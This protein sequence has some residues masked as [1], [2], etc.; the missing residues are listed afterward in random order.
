MSSTWASRN[1]SISGRALPADHDVLVVLEPR[2][3]D[4]GVLDQVD[5]QHHVHR[6]LQPGAVDLALA[7]AGVTVAEVEVRAFVEHR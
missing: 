2:P 1:A 5:A 7:L 6:R 3:V 4:T